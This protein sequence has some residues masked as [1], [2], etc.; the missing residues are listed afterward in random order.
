[1]LDIHKNALDS[2]VAVYHEFLGQYRKN[3]KVVYGFVEGKDDPVFYLGHIES[4]L[5]D[6]WDIKLF[7][8]G[9]KENVLKIH[10][11]IDWRS[12]KKKRICFFIDRDLSELI[13]ERVQRDSNIYVTTY[14]SVENYIV[15]SQVCERTLKEVY[16]F[17]IL[18]EPEIQKIKN[19]FSKE[20]ENFYKLMAPLM[21]VVLNWR[22]SGENANLN[23]VDLNKIFSF[24]D[25]IVSEKNSLMT[26]SLLHSQC[27][28]TMPN[29]FDHT[30]E[31]SEF[32]KA[33]VYRKFIRGKYLFWF[34]VEFCK[35]VYTSADKFITDLKRKPKKKLDL[36][37]GNGM[38]IVAPRARKPP[39]LKQFLELNYLEH[40]RAL[41]AGRSNGLN[42]GSLRH[43]SNR[44]TRNGITH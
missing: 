18:T 21:A 17:D 6:G 40:I 31:E 32:N 7:A 39:A 3:E 34:L 38:C 22:R 13:P 16:G 20:L 24:S 19:L 30:V 33:L 27:G 5:P 10:K 1:M 14:Y 9:G 36:S 28:V 37:L 2:K 26:L 42:L 4:T 11:S 35:S 25:G 43:Q 23:N 8:S 29:D 15:K 44:N 12:F 41:N